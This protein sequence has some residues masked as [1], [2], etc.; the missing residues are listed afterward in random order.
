MKKRM[1]SILLGLLVSVAVLPAAALAAPLSDA[2]NAAASVTVGAETTYYQYL[3]EALAKATEA[4]ATSE[5]TVTL[6]KN[7]EAN[8]VN[9]QTPS[10]NGNMYF[11][12]E[13]GGSDATTNLITLDGNRHT[14][15]YN[16]AESNLMAGVI[17]IRNCSVKIENI[18]LNAEAGSAGDYNQFNTGIE[19]IGSPN[20]TLTNC[21]INTHGNGFSTCINGE[22]AYLAKLCIEDGTKLL[23]DRA[24]HSCNDVTVQLSGG[25]FQGSIDASPSGVKSYLADGYYFFDQDGK[26]IVL[27]DG[28]TSLNPEGTYTVGKPEASVT[29]EGTTT[30]YATFAAAWDAAAPQIPEQEGQTSFPSATITLLEDA[31]DMERYFGTTLPTD[32]TLNISGKTLTL[33]KGFYLVP[34]SSLMIKGE[35]SGNGQLI[36]RNDERGAVSIGS[37]DSGKICNINV[38]NCAITV[39]QGPVISGGAA[40]VTIAR[41]TIIDTTP[42][43]DIDRTT[44]ISIYPNQGVED[45][46]LD[47]TN[48]TL[49]GPRALRIN[50]GVTATVADNSI[51][52]G[53]GTDW[54]AYGVQVNG[55]KLIVTGTSTVIESPVEGVYLTGGTLDFQS[56]IIQATGNLNPSD[57]MVSGI[58]LGD[59]GDDSTAPE[60]T[61]CGAVDSTQYGI[62]VVHGTAKIQDGASITANSEGVYLQGGK[63]LISGGEIM[64]TG[65]EDGSYGGMGLYAL[66]GT[67]EISGSAKIS[68]GQNGISVYQDSDPAHV[69][70]PT[71]VTIAGG[72]IRSTGETGSGLEVE[73]GTVTVTSGTVQGGT[74]E[75]GVGLYVRRGTVTLRGGTY[76]GTV[77]AVQG[78]YE[79]TPVKGLLA[80]G[81]AY[82]R[83]DD[84]IISTAQ[85]DDET[86]NSLEVAKV[87]VK[88][89]DP[90]T[91]ESPEPE[92]PGKMDVW[93]INGDDFGL[94]WEYPTNF[95]TTQV[96]DIHIAFVPEGTED[97]FLTD[98]K[99]YPKNGGF[100]TFTSNNGKVV[101]S[102]EMR[103]PERVATFPAGRYKGM[104]TIFAVGSQPI[105]SGET[106]RQLMI[107]E[108]NRAEV[109]SLLYSYGKPTAELAPLPSDCG[110]LEA[111]YQTAVRAVIGAGWMP[112][113]SD[114]TFSP[115]GPVTFGHLASIICQAKGWEVGA[116]KT[117]LDVLADHQVIRSAANI[118]ADNTATDVRVNVW[119]NAAFG[120]PTP[121][122]SNISY[123]YNTGVL[124]WTGKNIPEAQEGDYFWVETYRTGQEQPVQNSGRE[125]AEISDSNRVKVTRNG[126]SYCCTYKP[127]TLA[128]GSYEIVIM[129][130]YDIS[131]VLVASCP[132][133]VSQSTGGNTG[134]NTGGT[135][136]GNTG[137]SGS[138]GSSSSDSGSSDRDSSGSSSSSSASSN[139]TTSTT[140]N[141]DG[142]TTTKTENKSTGTVTET[143]KNTDGSTT[144][145]ETKKDGTVTTTGKAADG[146][147]A[148]VTTN[149]SGKTE[150]RVE[151]SAKAV[152]DAGGAPVTLPIA[153]V[154][155]TRDAGTAPVVTV[156]TG[157]GKPLKVEIPT[158]NPTPGTVAVI[159]NA[160]GTEE[161]IRTSVP[162]ENGVTVALPDGA[163]VKI[164]DKS[165]TFADACKVNLLGVNSY[166]LCGQFPISVRISLMLFPIVSTGVGVASSQTPITLPSTSYKGLEVAAERITDSAALTGSS[167]IQRT[168]PATPSSFTAGVKSGEYPTNSRRKL[169]P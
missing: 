126:D 121:D 4:S 154:T 136:G 60:A 23:G 133:T 132:F 38:E 71:N 33:D 25:T 155:A 99:A 148:T 72:T 39:E 100:V 30:H 147:T 47:I 159:V 6:L 137:S 5:V 45:V 103:D 77:S 84:T 168:Y 2:S 29:R 95:D 82:Y 83:E 26:E 151:L 89:G 34:G 13:I 165:K 107:S 124:S 112:G 140:K 146:S 16:D 98:D 102:Y 44:A 128:A 7:L 18:V 79:Q 123:N 36:V 3:K 75:Q 143:T 17:S 113:S 14:L 152:S 31:T 163:T 166:L 117:A 35:A 130:R 74:G 66:G 105:I 131:P 10:E 73:G 70:V 114:G 28:A 120:S 141:S 87:T 58:V 76:I 88:A 52:R 63:A 127:V 138:S 48:S 54:S 55:G 42:G 62:R 41:S 164:V 24:I 49:S 11:A 21:T 43:S 156:N 53:T 139:I 12:W 167:L 32:V 169:G 160:D 56:G 115:N 142:S 27:A 144:T 153:E 20:V 40:N 61:I 59:S 122:I 118:P 37:D 116:S 90:N 57:V 108:L 96:D 64:A 91:G 68:G 135:T 157:S 1:L 69:T 85:M 92:K 134:G 125:C 51:I 106:E 15:T 78:E 109:A 150:A 9:E 67:A 145:V 110:D 119:M 22:H 8:G 129:V 65:L 50:P 158:S 104:V 161:V 81:F 93:F 101:Y 97:A 46:T 86:P 149:A 111:A 19:L 94:G 162:T 80:S